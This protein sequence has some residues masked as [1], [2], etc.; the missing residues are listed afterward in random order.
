MPITLAESKPPRFGP[1]TVYRTGGK[2]PLECTVT[3]IWRT[4]DLAG[5]LVKTR[6]VSTHLFCGQTVTDHDVVETT[7]ARGLVKETQCQ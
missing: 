7:I 6:Y 1:G 4:Y 3:D 2:H 5:N